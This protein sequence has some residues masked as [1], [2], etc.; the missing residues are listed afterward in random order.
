MAQR[1]NDGPAEV[2]ELTGSDQQAVTGSC[3]FLGLDVNDD[4]SGTVHV[5]IHSGTDNTGPLIASAVPANGKHE[6]F[7][8]GPS[9]IKCP[10]G[11]YVDVT[12]GT[13]EGSIYYR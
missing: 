13:P 4:D 8:F 5:H 2:V 10:G 1:S 6:I 9:G 3:V 12:A 11:I 7:W